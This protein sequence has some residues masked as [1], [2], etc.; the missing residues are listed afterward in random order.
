MTLAHL[1]A[2]P[3]P[4]PP[5]HLRPPSPPPA[6]SSRPPAPTAARPPVPPVDAAT[7]RLMKKRLADRLYQR[8]HRAKREQLTR[9]LETAVHA[10]HDQIAH[11]RARR[12][13]AAARCGPSPRPVGPRELPRPQLHAHA[14]AIVNQY[15][16][17]FGAPHAPYGP[18]EQ[19]LRLVLSPQV[20][21]VDVCG[22]DG[23]V[24]Q[25]RLYALYC[26]AFALEPQC[27]RGR[28]RPLRVRAAGE[29]AVV[30]VDVTMRV[31]FCPQRI[32]DL[33]PRLRTI[34]RAHATRLMAPLVGGF[35]DAPYG[36][37]GRYRGEGERGLAVDGALTFVFDRTGVVSSFLVNLQL[38]DALRA[39]VGSLADVALLADGARIAFESGAIHAD[40]DGHPQSS[41]YYDY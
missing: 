38:M 25:L 1:L 30:D 3:P 21:G 5:L 11:L 8:R 9:E 20:D 19:F 34:P 27:G 36:Y 17:V 6:C 23:F 40:A 24:R 26:S 22:V 15:F 14:C 41:V 18:Q 37:G 32:A 28:P 13:D 29:F 2:V 39:A 31:R 33:F 35:A 16:R 12:Q 7:Q 10:L 4:L